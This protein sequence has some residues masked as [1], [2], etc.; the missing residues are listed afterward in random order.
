MEKST[1]IFVIMEQLRHEHMEEDDMLQ[2]VPTV[3][4]SRRQRTAL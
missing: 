3:P 1:Y 4:V 2:G